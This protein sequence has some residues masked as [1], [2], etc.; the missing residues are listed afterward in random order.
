MKVP[1]VDVTVSYKSVRLWG[2]GVSAEVGGGLEETAAQ[3]GDTIGGEGREEG[4]L[5]GKMEVDSGIVGTE[6]RLEGTGANGAGGTGANGAVRG[7]GSVGEV[8]DGGQEKRM[9]SGEIVGQGGEGVAESTTVENWGYM[10]T[11]SCCVKGAG[12]SRAEV[13]SR[14][15]EKTKRSRKTSRKKG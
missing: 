9:R 15:E 4:R 13:K 11:S 6:G 14:W 8:G 1:K 12:V 7:A 10:V 3:V 5:E 2:N